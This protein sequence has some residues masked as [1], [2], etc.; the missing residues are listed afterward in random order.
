MLKSRKKLFTCVLALLSCIVLLITGTGCY[1]VLLGKPAIKLA[2]GEQIYSISL[3][4]TGKTVTIPV[5]TDFCDYWRPQHTEYDWLVVEQKD[6]KLE[7]SANPIESGSRS[8]TV[9][10]LGIRRNETVSTAT[11][12]VKQSVTPA[13]CI[14]PSCG[15]TLDATG[16]TSTVRI[17]GE[18]WELRQIDKWFSISLE[19]N[20]LTITANANTTGLYRSGRIIVSNPGGDTVITIGQP[21][22]QQLNT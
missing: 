21:C 14:E 20:V 4:K 3:D 9:T 13:P 15:V 22:A 2:S 8:E 19:D 16:G 18:D 5:V 17:T 6:G 10:L 7:L 1:R 11:I 12:I